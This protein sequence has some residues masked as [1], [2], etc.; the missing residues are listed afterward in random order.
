M[1]ESVLHVTRRTHRLKMFRK[2]QAKT[3]CICLATYL[4]QIRPDSVTAGL[5]NL[6]SYRIYHNANIR[7][8]DYIQILKT[9][10]RVDDSNFKI[11]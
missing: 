1:Q 2:N 10:F 9:G 11:T 3:E 4:T 7:N 8:R 5:P 6:Y